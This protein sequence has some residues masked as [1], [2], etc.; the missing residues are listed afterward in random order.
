MCIGLAQPKKGIL[1]LVFSTTLIFA[2]HS[3]NLPYP[4]RTDR[5]LLLD[6]E[7]TPIINCP[8]VYRFWQLLVAGKHQRQTESW[9][10]IQTFRLH[11]KQS[12]NQPEPSIGLRAVSIS[13]PL[14]VPFSKN[15][16]ETNRWKFII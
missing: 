14:R 4:K 11:R 10:F 12:K 1:R 5:I 15:K 7:T 8:L 13:A 3:I 6:R 2:R 16:L 9:V